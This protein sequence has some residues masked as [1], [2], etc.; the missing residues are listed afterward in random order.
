MAIARRILLLLI[1]LGVLAAVAG[2]PSGDVSSRVMDRAA[3]DPM[4]CCGTGVEAAASCQAA[5]PSGS[6]V[7]IGVGLTLPVLDHGSMLIPWSA[8]AP[9]SLARAPDTTPPKRSVV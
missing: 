5:C 2:A 1:T 4:G 9:S 8:G 7:A 3:M 6:T